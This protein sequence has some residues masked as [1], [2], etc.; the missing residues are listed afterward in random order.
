M[1]NYATMMAPQAITK[2]YNLRHAGPPLF[3]ACPHQW[4]KTSSTSWSRQSRAASRLSMKLSVGLNRAPGV[5]F[6]GQLCYYQTVGIA[7]ER[8]SEAYD[9]L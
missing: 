5:Y 3:Q 6:Y 9:W 7:A 1:P 2:V 8:K 4:A